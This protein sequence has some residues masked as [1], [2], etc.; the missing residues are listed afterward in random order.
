[1]PIVLAN[2]FELQHVI[3]SLMLN[4]AKASMRRPP[5]TRRPQSAGRIDIRVRFRN[6]RIEITVQDNGEGIAPDVLPKIFD[7][8]VSTEAG[9]MGLDLK[10]CADIVKAHD[11]EISAE[12]NA[13]GGATFRVLLPVYSEREEVVTSSLRKSSRSRHSAQQRS[14]L[15]HTG[16]DAFARRMGD[17]FVLQVEGALASLEIAETLMQSAVATGN[18]ESSL[19]ALRN[20]HEHIRRLLGDPRK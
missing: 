1:M 9:G 14:A 8:N 15:A 7:S 10:I 12:N 5:S 11:G 2:R 6:P 17:L 4:G 20:A 3:V 19:K 18:V 13:E 16:T